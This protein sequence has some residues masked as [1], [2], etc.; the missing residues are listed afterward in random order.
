MNGSTKNFSDSELLA[1]FMFHLERSNLLTMEQ[2]AP[3]RTSQNGILAAKQL[4]ESGLLT[5]WQSDQLLA[6]RHSFFL[7]KYKLL[8]KLGEGGMGA[9][10]KAEQVSMKRL[11][12]AIRRA[13]NVV[14]SQSF[15]I[16]LD[17]LV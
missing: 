8:S 9:V 10:Y 6:G 13:A 1:E 7:G 4:I 12:C 2:I 17:R 11:G 5:G 3:F 15:L 16:A 14:Q